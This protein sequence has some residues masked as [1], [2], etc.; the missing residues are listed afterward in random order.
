[1]Q[2]SPDSTT[3][4]L[5]DANILLSTLLSNTLN[6]CSSLHAITIG[7]HVKFSIMVDLMHVFKF[8]VKPS[9]M[10]KITN[11]VM[12][13]MSDVMYDNLLILKNYNKLHGIRPSFRSRQ[14]FSRSRN[15]LLLL[16]PTVHLHV[17]KNLPLHPI[18]CQL[19]VIHSLYLIFL[20]PL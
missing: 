3:S 16:N 2:S 17:H 18:L 6:L 13:K 7:R 20:A 1:M 4:S 10:L 12:V 19:N 11:T 5:L 14:L 15:Y 9:F 8:C